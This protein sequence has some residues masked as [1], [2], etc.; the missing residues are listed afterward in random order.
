MGTSLHRQ[1]AIVATTP[2]PVLVVEDDPDLREA[3]VDTLNLAGFCT[4]SADNGMAALEVLKHQPVGLILSDAQMP[5]MDGYALFYEAKKHYPS[6]PFVLMTAYGVLEQA[7]ALLRAGA[8]HY[9]LK[10]FEPSVLVAEIEHRVLR[11]KSDSREGMVAESPIMQQTL[12]LAARIALSDV[13]VLLQGES[14]V[15]KEVVARYIHRHSMRASGAFVAVNCAAIPENLLE[16]TLFGHEKGAFT[17]A[18]A[19][20]AGKFEQAQG[21]TLLLDE[22][23]EMPLSLQAKL[24]RVLQ[25]KEL[26][27]VG[28]SK[29]IRLDVRVIGTTNRAL[30]DE[31][32][33]GHFREDLFYRINVFPLTI[34]PLRERKEDIVPLAQHF[35]AKHAGQQTPIKNLHLSTVAI[36]ELTGYEWGGNIRELENVMQRA[37]I[38]ASS[39]TIGLEDLML[40]QA[41]APSLTEVDVCLP[42]SVGESETMDSLEKRHILDTL[43]AVKGVRRLAAEKL[44][45]SERTLRYKL[46]RY[47]EQDAHL[48][49]AEPSST[50]R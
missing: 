12:A 25:E 35:L 38:L 33:A 14:G 27:R 42:P 6:V 46:Q 2:L 5:V 37:L 16:S 21:G 7:V 36:Q 17:G 47:R 23:S 34:P 1:V 29:T 15:G 10:P 24:L 28:G 32:R 30:Q 8:A 20:F 9:L 31:V 39:S 44:G 18:S 13:S 4:L 22:I 43:S 26:E 3:V 40:A 19:Q 41:E 49:H 45:I 11:P 50:Q 48:V